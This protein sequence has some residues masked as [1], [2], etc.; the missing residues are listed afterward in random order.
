MVFSETT[1]EGFIFNLGED[2]DELHTKFAHA[3]PDLVDAYIQDLS[4]GY[5]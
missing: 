4:V 3:D 2:R 5:V 1:R